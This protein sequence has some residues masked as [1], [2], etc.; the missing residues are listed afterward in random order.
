MNE[1]CILCESTLI[2]TYQ[3][4][5]LLKCQN[6]ALV[7]KVSSQLLSKEK[8]EQRYLLHKNTIEDV[9]YLK[10]LEPVLK[11]IVGNYQK[12]S[13]GLDYGSGPTPVLTELLTRSGYHVIPYD[14]FF[15]NININDL[16]AINFITCTEVAEHFYNPK[17]EF[18]NIFSILAPLGQLL[19]M[20]ELYTAK[21]DFTKWYYAQDIT[22]VSFYCRKTL[23]YLARMYSS[24]LV[25]VTD[26]VFEFQKRI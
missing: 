14:P 4:E 8:E 6:C 24:Q 16:T 17:K 20:T 23:D 1:K 13:K 10:F 7:F 2:E 22:H 11:R 21:T 3:N 19:L 15:S 5:I 18:Q 26:R 12:D 9:G 25:E